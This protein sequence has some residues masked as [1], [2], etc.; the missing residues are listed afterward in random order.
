MTEEILSYFEKAK[1][2]LK[3]EHDS[4]VQRIKDDIAASKRKTLS[5]V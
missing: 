2:Q 3:S 5:K 4:M 1:A